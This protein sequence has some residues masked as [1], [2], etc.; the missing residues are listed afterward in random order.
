MKKIQ[1]KFYTD[2]LKDDEILLLK[3]SDSYFKN[4][5]ESSPLSV[6]TNFKGTAGEA[7]ID[8]NGNITIF[9]DTRYHILVDKQVF[10]DIEVVKIELGESFFEAFKKKYKKGTILHVSKDISLYDYIKLDKYFDLRTYKLPEKFLKNTELDISQPLYLCSKKV[11]KNTFLYKINKLKQIYQNADKLLVFNLDQIS[12]LTNIRSF[13]T[14]YSS[15]FRSILLIDFKTKNHILFLD[16]LP[17]IKIS[18]LKFEKLSDFKNVIKSINSPIYLNYK[19]ITL[20][21]F[22]AVKKPKEIKNDNLSLISSIK[23][24]SEIE[25][26]EICAKKLDSAIYNFKKSIKAGISEYNLSK[27][28][29]AELMKTG[30]KDLSFKTI[31][32]FGENSASIHYSSPSKD[33]LLKDESIILLDCG[34]YW[35][36]GFA[37][38]ITRTFYFGSHPLP[39]YKKVYTYVLK[40]FI[41]CFLSKETD[42]KKLDKSA[43]KILKP[44]EKEGFYFNHGLGHGIGT[45]VHQNPPVL[46]VLSSDI[47]KP[48]QTH[49]IEPGL[50]GGKELKFGVRLENCVWFDLDFNR[51]SLTKFPFEEVLIEYSLLTKLEKDFLNCWQNNFKLDKK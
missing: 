23:T 12:Y 21:N 36:N 28:F 17:D 47:I 40:A 25:Y 49:S 9:V 2:I 42:A 8:K 33:V 35:K 14:K 26:I 50:Y 39:I 30:A 46:S 4:H 11:E 41:N 15:L 38:D 48:Y 18:G 51:Y 31:L 37:T 24:K 20:E 27:I 34:G 32:A 29:E 10:D 3:S 13:Q 5:Y 45:S 44:L 22:L 16:I 19:D 7:I 1:K 43:R 6:L